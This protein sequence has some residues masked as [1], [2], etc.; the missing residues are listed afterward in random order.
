MYKTKLGEKEVTLFKFKV[1]EYEKLTE[2]IMASSNGI[3]DDTILI[4]VAYKPDKRGRFYK[5][6]V[7]EGQT[8]EF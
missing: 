3:P 5:R 8:K 1:E 4:C 6:I 7:K 2:E